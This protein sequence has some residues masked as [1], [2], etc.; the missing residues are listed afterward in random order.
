VITVPLTTADV[1]SMRFAY[2][3][4][5]EVAE[6][7]YMI[8]SGR[9]G[10]FHRPWFMAVRNELRRVDLTLLNAIVPPRPLIADFL[11]AGA[12]DTG[13]RI[14]D[15]LKRVA[16]TPVDVLRRDVEAVWQ[17]EPVAPAARAV[18]GDPSGPKRL[19]EA[20][21]EYWSVAIEPNWRAMRAVLDDDVAH[22]G[23]ELTKG[24][25]GA[26]LA[27]LH[28]SVSVIGDVLHVDKPCPNQ[29]DLAS[30]GMT[31]VP[32]VFTWPSVIFARSESR[33]YSL[34]YTAR[35]V[36]NPW[37]DGKPSEAGDDPLAAL[38]GRGR[39]AV[40]TCLALPMSTTELAVRLRLSPPAISQ[41]LAIL[42]RSGLATSWRSG[43]RVLYRRSAL[44]DSI[45]AANTNRSLQRATRKRGTTPINC[46]PVRHG[47]CRDLR[48]I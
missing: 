37:I 38:L 45:V 13:T 41:H 44:A 27:G 4:L 47:A 26:M 2:S 33:A 14:E 17:D 46:Q 21:W 23:T 40:L 18:L 22:R 8:A 35:G 19:V 15:Q 28:P 20:L 25:L 11:F 34:M 6:S 10:L 48:G 24:G 29:E 36:A 42:R 1:Q 32:S 43:R 39:A 9:V 30:G 16:E 3:P 5:A 12:T 31:L 7:L